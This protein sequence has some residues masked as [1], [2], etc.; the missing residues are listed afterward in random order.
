METKNLVSHFWLKATQY[1]LEIFLQP[2]YRVIRKAA[3][4]EWCPEQ[5]WVLQQ[6]W[7]ECKQLCCWRFG[8]PY[9]VDDARDGKCCSAASPD[10]R[11]AMQTLGVLEQDHASC[12]R[13]L[14]T[15]W[16]TAPSML[17]GPV[18]TGILDQR[19]PSDCSF[20]TAHYG[21][22]FVRLTKS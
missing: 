22:G 4:S 18:R 2:I 12:S 21:V 6:M 13:E 8:R 14:H 11:L 1:H 15:L 10:E 5:K 19:A 9:A 17:L 20:K 7:A 16:E 3:S